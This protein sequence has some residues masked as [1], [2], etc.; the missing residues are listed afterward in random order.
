LRRQFR[1]PLRLFCIL[2]ILHVHTSQGS[3]TCVQTKLVSPGNRLGVDMLISLGKSGMGHE[4]VKSFSIPN[5]SVSNITLCHR[6]HVAHKLQVEQACSKA[7]CISNFQL[8][9]PLTTHL[10]PRLIMSVAIP[11]L[12]HMSSWC[13]W[14]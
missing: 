7:S 13:T 6:Q 12:G 9:W 2:F 5:V 3:E 8:N 10:V 11:P 1:A 14:G 4:R